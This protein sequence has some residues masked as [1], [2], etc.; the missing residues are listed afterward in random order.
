MA[1]QPQLG[2]AGRQAAEVDGV[3]RNNRQ[4]KKNCVRSLG[5]HGAEA[6]ICARWNKP[7]PPTPLTFVSGLVRIRGTGAGA[8]RGLAPPA[9]EAGSSVWDREHLAHSNPI[10]SG[11]SRLPFQRLLRP[12]LGP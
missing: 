12:C 11:C 8:D 6:V 1:S 9:T 10:V 2:Q 7:C 4:K 3:V 5:G